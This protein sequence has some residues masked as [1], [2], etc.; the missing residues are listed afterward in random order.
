MPF[1][2]RFPLCLFGIALMIESPARA[3]RSTSFS[4]MRWNGVAYFSGLD[5]YP[6]AYGGR[7][8][9]HYTEIT[10]KNMSS[11]AQTVTVTATLIGARW[12][13]NGT[14]GNADYTG[15]V[16]FRQLKIGDWNDFSSPFNLQGGISTNTPKTI[17]TAP[18]LLQPQGAA[19]SDAFAGFAVEY[20]GNGVNQG[21]PLSPD[22]NLSLTIQVKEDRGAITAALS[23][24]CHA[25]GGSINHGDNWLMLM[26]VD[27]LCNRAAFFNGTRPF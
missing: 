18:L 8:Y 25:H 12:G 16:T 17:S 1:C 13:V 27:L 24:K 26:A 10:I 4:G 5:N 15:A 9:G 23:E 7:R 20:W 21:C 11:I 2:L 14:C 22:G 6:Q 19:G 3:S